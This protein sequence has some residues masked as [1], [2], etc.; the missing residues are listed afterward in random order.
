MDI[1]QRTDILRR[2]GAT[3]AQSA[4]L[5]AYIGDGFDGASASAHAYPLSD[6]P[7]VE[8]WREYVAEAR[9]D[10]T[11]ATL[12]RHLVQLSFPIAKGI[13]ETDAYRAATRRG[14]IPLESHPPAPFLVDED[15]LRITLHPTAAGTLPIIIAR[16]RSDFEY[17]VCALAHRNE[18]V[19]IPP[20]L[21]ACIVGGYNNWSRVE[22]LRGDWLANGGAD[23]AVDAD[24]AWRE[25]FR[26]IVPH[27]E[28]YQDRFAIL[29]VGPYS[30]TPASDVGLGDDE[31]LRL[32]LVIRLEHECAHYFTKRVFG[33]M[34][35]SLLDELIAD[36][37]GIVA[38][39]G[40]F[41][42]S[43][44]LRFMGLESRRTWRSSGRLANYRGSPPLSDGAFAV[45]HEMVRRATMTLEGFDAHLRDA[46][47][48]PEHPRSLDEVGRAIVAIASTGLEPLADQGGA[49]RLFAAFTGQEIA[50]SRKGDAALRSPTCGS[51]CEGEEPV[52]GRRAP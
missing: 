5:I 9:H 25:Q 41:E 40:R 45:L 7:F 23:A 44:L 15:G 4:E 37:R 14:I 26:R 22:R 21:G 12:R 2:C 18:P 11:A 33:T 27:R 32:S 19:P 46:A 30:A 28:R 47:D 43:W 38:A 6:E 49:Q 17:L 10:G 13:S 24:M 39:A 35:N 42:P 8:A 20:S 51:A 36:Y 1:A 34:R 50:S 31:W 29:S 52:V 48:G 16:V 3:A